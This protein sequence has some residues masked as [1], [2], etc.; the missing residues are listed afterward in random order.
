MQRYYQR[1]WNDHDVDAIDGLVAKDFMIHRDKL[2]LQGRD[3][4]K[5]H[6]KE[7]MINFIDLRVHLEGIV[8]MRETVAIRLNVWHQTARGEQV[9]YRGVDVSTVRDGLITETSVSYTPAEIV[10]ADDAKKLMAW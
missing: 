7:T 8:A 4:L 2:V 6:V 1:V 10:P 3:A 5:A 9:R